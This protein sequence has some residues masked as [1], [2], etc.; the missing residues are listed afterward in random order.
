MAGQGS[1]GL[2]SWTNESKCLQEGS[3]NQAVI[4]RAQNIQHSTFNLLISQQHAAASG[5]LWYLNL[6]DPEMLHEQRRSYERLMNLNPNRPRHSRMPREFVG[7]VRHFVPLLQSDLTSAAVTWDC[8]TVYQNSSLAEPG[9]S[10]KLVR[11]FLCQTEWSADGV[12]LNVTDLDEGHLRTVALQRVG[13]QLVAT[14]YAFSEEFSVTAAVKT[15]TEM[16]CGSPKISPQ[17]KAAHAI[18]HAVM[19][20]LKKYKPKANDHDHQASESGPT[21]T[22]KTT[23]TCQPEQLPTLC[24][25]DSQQVQSAAVETY[26]QD[27]QTVV[28]NCN[29]ENPESW[30]FPASDSDS[31]GWSSD[32][33]SDSDSDSDRGSCI[34]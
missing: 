20:M 33:D 21:L 2:R 30:C 9:N 23:E 22:E 19:G 28:F 13:L 26:D 27:G 31:D 15:D 10:L 29:T 4:F 24:V 6:D 8:V 16:C 32:E 3:S 11:N 5:P 1:W 14:P 17:S 7:Q 12:P 25:A 34:T 18:D